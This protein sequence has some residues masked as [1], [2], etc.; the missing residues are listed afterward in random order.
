MSRIQPLLDEYAASHQNETN[1]TV[2]WICVPLIFMSVLGL[3]QSIP[4][5]NFFGSILL[6]FIPFSWAIIC[7]VL[8]FIYYLQLSA[9]LAF[10]M[11][12]LSIIFLWI[13]NAIS[14]FFGLPVWEVSIII[15]VLAWIGQFWGHKI[16]GKKPSF[17]KDLQFLLIGPA[18]L[19]HFIY[20]KVG[21]SY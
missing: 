10:G 19:L 9:S 7:L 11:L 4:S 21:I 17:L 13:I 8:A 18:W 16:E 20:L 3:L 2:H 12:L 5:P 6:G 15:F 1:K 14:N